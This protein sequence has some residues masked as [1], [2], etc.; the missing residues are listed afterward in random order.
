MLPKKRAKVLLFFDM[1]K[2]FCI[3]YAERVDF[4][5]Y[6]PQKLVAGTIFVGENTKLVDKI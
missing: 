3:F 1:T 4:F 6:V 2:Y 5:A